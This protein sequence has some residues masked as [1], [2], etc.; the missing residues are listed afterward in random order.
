MKTFTKIAAQGELTF[1]RLPDDTPIPANAQ[2]VA[3]EG[4]YVIVGHSE[5]G[6]HHVMLAER[7]DL[8]KLPDD[9]MRCII[10]VKDP[11]A[12]THQREFD[13]HEPISFAPGKYEVRRQREYTPQGWR[14]S[15]D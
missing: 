5:T 7:T 14:A 15:Q 12:L 10:D 13:Q 4:K 2:R 6:H 3:P 9:L 11:D 1:I 8:Y